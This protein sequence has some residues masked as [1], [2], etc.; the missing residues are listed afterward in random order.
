MKKLSE[1]EKA[2]RRG[3]EEYLKKTF[4]NPTAAL[5]EAVRFSSKWK[6]K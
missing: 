2:D 3:F 1:K 4:G 5:T 6:K